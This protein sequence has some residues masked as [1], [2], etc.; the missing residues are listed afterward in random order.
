MIKKISS[1][2]YS[3]QW[4]PN[5]ADRNSPDWK[6]GVEIIRDRFEYRFFSP[7]EVLIKHT[8]K[9]IRVNSGFVIMSIDCLLIETLNQ[10]YLGLKKTNDKYNRNNPDSNYKWNWQAFRDFFL[11]KQLFFRF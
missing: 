4:T 7:I 9:E 6:L 3:N 5:L 11:Q 2:H 1:S 8:K 10:F